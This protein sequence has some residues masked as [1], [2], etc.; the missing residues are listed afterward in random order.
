MDNNRPTVHIVDDNDAV[1]NSIGMSLSV[2]G[3]VVKE[4][5]SASAFLNDYNNE[6]G[7][8]VADI[9]MPVMNGLEL[10]QK[11]LKL[12]LHIPIIFITGHG[13]I[14]MSVQAIKAG[15]V[16]FLEKP[17]ERD[18]LIQCVDSALQKDARQQELKHDYLE[19]SQRLST[20]TKRER[21]VLEHLV[22]DNASLTN[23]DISEKLGISKHT[24]EVLF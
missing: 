7:C 16:E 10:Q 22:K 11:L 8:L 4:Y 2:K 19:I 24:I 23:K 17:F 15:A 5:E 6:P 20:L 13:D 18:K 14:P 9:Q 12:K 1:R 3:Y 21:E